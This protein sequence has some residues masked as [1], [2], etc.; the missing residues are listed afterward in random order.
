M[1]RYD[2]R[3]GPECKFKN[4]IGYFGAPVSIMPAP[5]MDLIIATLG[6]RY[7]Y[8]ALRGGYSPPDRVEHRQGRRI[9][10]PT[11]ALLIWPA[12]GHSQCQCAWINTITLHLHLRRPRAWDCATPHVI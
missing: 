7:R 3:F 1:R 5:F 12:R 2:M 9:P 11:R 4:S 10:A 8:R 6:H